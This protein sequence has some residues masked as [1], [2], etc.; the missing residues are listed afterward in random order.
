MIVRIRVIASQDPKATSPV[1]LAIA[2]TFAALAGVFHGAE[3]DYDAQHT[4][5][6][7]TRG[8]SISDR[9]FH[10]SLGAN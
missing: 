8:I 7:T 1:A 6:M 9:P 4:T 2:R 3:E 10:C 5:P